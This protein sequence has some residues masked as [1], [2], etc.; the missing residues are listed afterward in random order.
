MLVVALAYSPFMP[1]WLVLKRVTLTFISLISKVYAV[2]A[3]GIVTQAKQMVKKNGYQDI[4]EIINGK[5]EEITLPVDSVD[6]IVSEWMGYFL[7]CVSF[8]HLTPLSM[9]YLP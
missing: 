2:D 1:Q 8:L 7:F 3:S 4:I 9:I 5:I 6:M